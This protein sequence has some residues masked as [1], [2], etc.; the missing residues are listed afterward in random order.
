MPMMLRQCFKILSQNDDC[1]Q[2]H[3]V[4]RNN[5]FHFA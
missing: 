1:L 2:T 5:P 4:D 3:C